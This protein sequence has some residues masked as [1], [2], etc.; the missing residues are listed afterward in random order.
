MRLRISSYSCVWS[1]GVPGHER[2][3]EPFSVWSLLDKAVPFEKTIAFRL[4]KT[5]LTPAPA[6]L[7]RAGP[8]G[9]IPR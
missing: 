4:Q 8:F 6:I 5:H 3:R 9:S 2:P 1:G 7:R